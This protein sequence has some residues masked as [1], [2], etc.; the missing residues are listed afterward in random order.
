MNGKICFSSADILIPKENLEKWSVIACDQYTSE[1]EYWEK[2]KKE[3]G[4]GP[5]ALKCI[6]PEVYLSDNP[7]KRIENADKEMNSY[8]ESG[9]FE[10]Y[11]DSLVFVKR[12][13]SDGK[14]RKGIVGKI[15]LTC[16]DFSK[17]NNAEVRAT[18]E[19]VLSR[20]PPRVKIRENAPLEM[21]HVMLLFDDPEDKIFGKLEKSSAELKK[22]YDFDLML[23]GGSISG[24]SVDNANKEF[25]FGA[26]EEIKSK[27]NGLLFCVGDGNHSLATAKRCYELNPNELNKFALVEIVNIHD[28][29]LDFEPIYRVLFNVSPEEFI[30]GFSSFCEHSGGNENREYTFVFGGKKIT[31]SLKI[32]QKLAVA[33]LTEFIDGY[34]S[35]HTDTEVDYIHGISSVEKLSG[36]ENTL[37]ILFDGMKKSE[38]FDAVLSDGSLPRKTFSMGHADDKR[39]YLEAR[40]IK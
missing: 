34:L 2:A 23:G 29:A 3:A 27:H 31:K 10:E 4:E 39:F 1:P 20:I 18:E 38:L 22:L 33:A 16:Y 28:T 37:G 19:T 24:Y 9:V 14:I 7:E 36:G 15:D 11:K 8:L 35:E 26:L 30:D 12:K 25:I 17:Q 32:K 5:S 21:P 40:K 13:Q 6:L